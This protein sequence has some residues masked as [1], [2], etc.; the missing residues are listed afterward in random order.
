MNE[1]WSTMRQVPQ[2]MLQERLE[3]VKELFADEQETELYEVVKDKATGEHYLH[4]AYMHLAIAEG[5][6]ESFHQLLPLDS[7]DV[8]AVLFGE[9]GYA[10][11]EFWRKPFLRNGPDGAYVWFDPTEGWEGAAEREER[12]AGEIVGMLGD[13]KRKGEHD[14]ESV[15]RLLD[16]IER[17]FR[18]NEKRDP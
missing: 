1:S 16:Q 4:Y 8:L 6:R 18:E 14:A 2:N 9:Q 7:D 5:T 17:T 10:Y 13:W 12:L 11:P 3:T 15:K